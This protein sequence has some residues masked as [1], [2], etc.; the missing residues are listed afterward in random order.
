MQ[1]IGVDI[2]GPF[3]KSSEGNLYVQ[4][5]V[6]LFTSW[7][8][9]LPLKEI[10][11]DEVCAAFFKIIISRHGCPMKLIS[12]RCKQ[13]E[14]K[15]FNKFCEQFNIEHVMASAYHHQTNGK[16]ERFMKFIENSFALTVD[17]DQ[18]NWC[19]LLDN[20]LFT[21]RVSISRMLNESPFYLIYG[22]DPILPA[23]LLIAG[24]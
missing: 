17:K 12:D 18:K 8:E 11:A 15:I 21:Y 19:K 9:A 3:T 16:A 5:C 24:K 10:T 23:D 1:Q 22:R 20:C 14:S 4:V 13:F 7:V 2:L 6:D